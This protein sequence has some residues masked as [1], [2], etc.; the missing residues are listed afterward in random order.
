MDL[1]LTVSKRSFH[2][3]SIG[4]HNMCNTAKQSTVSFYS[5][6]F[7]QPVWHLQVLGCSLNGFGGIWQTVKSPHDSLVILTTDMALFCDNQST[8]RLQM[9]PFGSVKFLKPEVL[10]TLWLPITFNP[11]RSACDIDQAMKWTLEWWAIQLH[12]YPMCSRN[13]EIPRIR[14]YRLVEKFMQGALSILE[15]HWIEYYKTVFLN[16]YN[17][18]YNTSFCKSGHI[19]IGL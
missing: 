6:L 8:R 10:A 12:S 17:C 11:Y 19:F 3:N 14:N 16:I 18:T 15:I 4:Q 2:H 5:G 13:N 9:K 1:I 7:L